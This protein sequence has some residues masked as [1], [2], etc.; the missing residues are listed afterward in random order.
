MSKNV[1]WVRE[2]FLNEAAAQNFQPDESAD[3]GYEDG[4]HNAF[5][6]VLEVVEHDA[7]ERGIGQAEINEG[8]ALALQDLGWR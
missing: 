7:L 6:A 2:R 4:K 8:V 5:E 3:Y 1:Q